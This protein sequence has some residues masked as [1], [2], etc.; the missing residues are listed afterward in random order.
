MSAAVHRDIADKLVTL[1]NQAELSQPFKAVRSK[2]PG[3]DRNG[4]Q[5]TLHVIVTARGAEVTNANRIAAHH[6]YLTEIA[7]IKLWN[8]RKTCT[9][10]R[11]MTWLKKSRMRFA[12]STWEPNR[13]PPICDWPMKA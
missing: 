9:P 3:Y 10:I 5:G 12:T 13:T 11:W 6:D 1:L 7:V 2:R 4:K 8:P